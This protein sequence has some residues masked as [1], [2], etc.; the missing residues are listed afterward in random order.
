MLANNGFA[1]VEIQPLT[2]GINP[3]APKQRLDS[4]YSWDSPS[5]YEHI[6]A[7]MEQ[8]KLSGITVDLNGGS[9]W[10]IGGP[11]VAPGESMLTLAY[12]DTVLNADVD[13]DFVINV[14]DRLPYYADITILIRT[15]INLSATVMQNCR[16]Y[17][18]P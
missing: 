7:V 12:S 17:M 4:I 9:G 18:Q 3:D 1:G 13:R 8:A 10:P 6:A 14:P 5:F 16:Q 15:Y 11:Q 2:M